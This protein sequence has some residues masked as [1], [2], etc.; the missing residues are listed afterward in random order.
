MIVF[1]GVNLSFSNFVRK[2]QRFKLNITE[3]VSEED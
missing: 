1:R 3:I 2:V